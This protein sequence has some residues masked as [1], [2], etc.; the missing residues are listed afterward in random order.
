[1]PYHDCQTRKNGLHAVDEGCNIHDK[2]A[3][4]VLRPKDQPGS[5]HDGG[6]GNQGAVLEF[7]FVA[8]AIKFRWLLFK[9]DVLEKIIAHIP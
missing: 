6:A 1:M 2:F 7:M 4:F 5:G 3:P 9:I 8:E